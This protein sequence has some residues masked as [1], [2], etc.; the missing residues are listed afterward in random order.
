[1]A[2]AES[3]DWLLRLT[4][5]QRNRGFGLCFLYLRN[6]KGFGWNPKRV[7]RI[8]RALELYLRFKPKKRLVRAKPQPL[9][10]PAAPNEA[11]RMGDRIGLL[12]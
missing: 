9:A 7:Y 1:M 12:M 11:W 5:N 8:N 6:M 4:H 10:E 3:A 2:K